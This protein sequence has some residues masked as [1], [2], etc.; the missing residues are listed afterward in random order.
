[1]VGV[2]AVVAL[3]AYPFV[4][5]V[6]LTRAGARTAAAALL[7]FLA[8]SFAARRFVAR[9]PLRP[10]LVQHATAGA[11]AALALAQ[12]APTALLLIPALPSLAL[13]GVFAETLR[14]GPPMIER[15]A[16]RISGPAFR[17]EMAGHCRQATVAWCVFFGVNALV[18]GALALAAPLDWW[19]LYTGVLTYLAMAATFVAEFAVRR[20]RKARLAPGTAAGPAPV[21]SE[22]RPT[23]R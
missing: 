1:V 7:A 9:E 4:L 12:G 15:F 8:L 21:G 13:L 18:I 17:E 10:L 23:S 19:A 5:R 2:A 6:L 11:A 14:R 20:L 3:V 22:P 16:R